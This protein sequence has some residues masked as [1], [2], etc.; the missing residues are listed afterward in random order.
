MFGSENIFFALLKI[1]TN[2]NIVVDVSLLLP[3]QLW[4]TGLKGMDIRPRF[5]Y[6]ICS[7]VPK[8]NHVKR[9]D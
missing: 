9:V 7:T 2:Q 6:S 8:K 5:L 3:R 4:N 1:M